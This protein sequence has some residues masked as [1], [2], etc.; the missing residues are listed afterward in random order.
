MSRNAYR[1]DGRASPQPADISTNVTFHHEYLDLAKSHQ[2][3]S[4]LYLE[5]ASAALERA[6]DALEA[7]EDAFNDLMQAIERRG[8]I[9]P[10]AP[11]AEVVH[12][13]RANEKGGSIVPE[14][15][16]DKATNKPAPLARANKEGRGIARENAPAKAMRA[17]SLCLH[18][19]FFQ[20]LNGLAI[21]YVFFLVFSGKGVVCGQIK[22]NNVAQFEFLALPVA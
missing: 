12:E 11:V 1:Q 17:K 6:W 18:F 3:R 2:Q 14:T 16:P 13:P 15:T 5:A 22:G 21:A 20:V 4:R 19:F 7:Y 9:G 10:D 8:G